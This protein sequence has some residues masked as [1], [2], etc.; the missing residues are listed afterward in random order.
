MVRANV[1]LQAEEAAVGAPEGLCAA[2]ASEFDRFLCGDRVSHRGYI[3]K[4][5]DCAT[6]HIFSAFRR[7]TF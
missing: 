2:H 6:A 4:Q 7:Q 3:S 1:R 5:M